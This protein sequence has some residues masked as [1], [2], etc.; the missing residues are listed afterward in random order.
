MLRGLRPLALCG[1]QVLFT[2][3]ALQ[4]ALRDFYTAQATAWQACAGRTIDGSLI[5]AAPA[6]HVRWFIGEVTDTGELLSTINPQE[7]GR[8]WG[9]RDTAGV[10]NNV[11]VRVNS[12]ANNV[13]DA[14]GQQTIAAI[15][16]RIDAAD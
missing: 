10:R 2:L 11:F 1:R 5:T 15:N 12:C 16:A 6:A 13:G 14:A 9:C 8:G 3:T 4:R 7:G